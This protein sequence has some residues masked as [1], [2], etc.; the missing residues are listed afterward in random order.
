MK[1]VQGN[2]GSISYHKQHKPE[3]LEQSLP[4]PREKYP[5]AK[6]AWAGSTRRSTIWKHVSRGPEV[7]YVKDRFQ[8]QGNRSQRNVSIY[9]KKQ[10]IQRKIKWAFYFHFQHFIIL[11]FIG[12]FIYLDFKYYPLSWIPLQKTIFNT[13]SP[14]I[15]DSAPPDIYPPLLPRLGIILHWSIMVSQDQRTLLLLIPENAI[16]LV[17]VTGTMD[18]SMCTLWLVV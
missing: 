6:R 13:P 18:H 5:S 16:L 12:Y 1:P 4:L 7:K 3:A 11:F 2:K 8:T 14:Y 17:Y 15:Y 10:N 9:K